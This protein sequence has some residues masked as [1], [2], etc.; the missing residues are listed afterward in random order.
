MMLWIDFDELVEAFDF[1]SENLNFFIDLENNKIIFI[2]KMEENVEKKLEK[3]RGDRYIEIPKNEPKDEL[4]IMESFIY[5]IHE[6]GFELAEKFH[7][8]L[9]KKTPFRNFKELLKEQGEELEIKWHKFREKEFRNNVINWLCQNDFELSYNIIPKIEI[10][11][12]NREEAENAIN[13]LRDFWP[14]ACMNCD[15]KRNLK[16]R[17]FM[18]NISIENAMIEKEINKILMEKYALKHFGYYMNEKTV[19]VAS[20]CP[21]CGSED[22]FWDY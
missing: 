17:F 12:L 16:Q 9:E 18:L 2:N 10:N 21:V 8:A 15:N 13:E 22:I 14:T 7:E 6:G 3:I 5:E 20:K 4:N 19:I 1:C 11:E